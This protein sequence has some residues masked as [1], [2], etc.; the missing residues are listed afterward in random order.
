MN[1]K[2]YVPALIG[3][4]AA[5]VVASGR[6]GPVIPSIRVSILILDTFGQ[7]AY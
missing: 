5:T 3:A 2:A 1:R 6:G 4:G 7:T